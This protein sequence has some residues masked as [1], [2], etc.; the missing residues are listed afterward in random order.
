[1]LKRIFKKTTALALIIILFTSSTISVLSIKNNQI[2]NNSIIL[3]YNF[4]DIS[5]STVKI[6]NKNQ[7]RLTID[8]LPL[9]GDPGKPRVPVKPL[10]I[11]L[12]KNSEIKELTLTHSEPEI[13]TVD[14]LNKIEYATQPFILNNNEI[15]TNNNIIE[16]NT[17]S[18]Y[19]ENIYKNLGV[20][21]WHGYKILHINLYPVR[22]QSNTNEIF[23]YNNIK[24]NIETQESTNNKNII[25]TWAQKDIQKHV[26]NPYDIISYK[27]DIITTQKSTTYDYIIITSDILIETQ[28]EYNFNDLIN[29]RQNQGLTCLIK[30]VE[31][32]NVEYP[33]RDI[34][35][36]IRNFIKY[37][38]E[39][40]DTQWVLLGGDEPHV[41]VRKL[42]DI[43]GGDGYFESDL[44]YQCLDG[45]FNYDEDS[46]WGEKF[47]G[48]NGER[49]DLYAEVYIGRAPA[50]NADDVSA[51]V[52]KTI[53]YENSNWSSDVYLKNHLASGEYVWNS[54]GGYGAGYT[55]RCIDYCDDYNQ[56]TNGIP[57]S[58]YNIIELYERDNP[59]VYTDAIEVINQGVN[60]IN[61][62]G[63]GT[64]R[65]AMKI[66]VDDVPNLDNNGEYSLFYSQACHSG[67]FYYYDCI[68]ESWLNTPKKGGFAAIMNSGYGYGG[69]VDF[70]GPDN[71]YAREFYDALF[72]TDEK[73]SR[74]GKANQ[75]S[76]QDNYYRIDEDKMYHVYYDTLLFGDPYVAIK[77]AEDAQAQFNWNPKYP[78]TSESINFEDISLGYIIYR[79]WDFGDGSNSNEENPNHTYTNPGIY[80]ITLTVWDTH[81][82]S[83]TINHEV[84][85][86]DQWTPHAIAS[87]DYYSGN[88]YSIQFDAIES[89]DPDGSIINYE[90]DFDDG[91]Y[92]NEISPL[93][94]FSIAGW[95]EVK[96]TVTDNDNNIDIVTCNIGIGTQ[97]PPDTPQK[98]SGPNYGIL[99]YQY[100]FSTQTFD[101]END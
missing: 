29:H 26:E 34:Q 86:R 83:S 79:E 87:P 68:A 72:S 49:I 12:P 101:V 100:T 7:T 50:D 2:D 28:G 57:S 44:Y 70:D 38:Y 23:Y 51:F 56:I 84:E 91:L 17:N 43:D 16:F 64:W 96:L 1:M 32:I 62:V 63:H 6:L 94:D 75:D 3:E 66:S 20:Q 93:H 60:I 45:N 59:W 14:N 30:T 55:E 13:Y 73:I 67:H 46:N 47:D 5:F 61:H 27:N 48:E 99:S 8:N 74:I 19:P 77:G 54:T 22:Y 97:M 85:I 24:I 95:Y 41:P 31:D 58:E 4:E 25:K 71:R 18:I 88:L 21:Y 69:I 92:S 80:D 42:Y 10:R 36:K 40:F 89:W 53:I 98:P 37:C 76:K 82:E 78:K 81:G 35:E 15:E 11:L 39:N 9:T 90:W 65:A 33:G 52:E